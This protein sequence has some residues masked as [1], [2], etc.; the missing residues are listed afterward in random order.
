MGATTVINMSVGTAFV[1]GIVRGLG[2][3][4]PMARSWTCAGGNI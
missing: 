1:E 3:P 2:E 4:S